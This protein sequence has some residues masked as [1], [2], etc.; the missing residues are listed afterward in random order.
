MA[1]P[2]VVR[3]KLDTTGE[4]K[5]ELWYAVAKT[6]Q[7]KGGINDEEFIKRIAQKT[8]FSPGVIEGLLSEIAEAIEFFLSY[9]FTVNLKKLGS[10]QT[11]LTS[12]GFEHPAE[13]TPAEV[14]LSR[15]YFV[16]NRKMT[17]RIRESGYYK[18]PFNSYLPK[19]FWEKEEKEDE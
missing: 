17:S 11:A 18:V 9:G 14:N 1:I 5:K 10:F 12:K 19:E 6:M 8:G 13:V 2:Y 15:V 7:E 16:A 3:K 4:E